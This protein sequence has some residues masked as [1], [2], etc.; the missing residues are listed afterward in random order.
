MP[1][2]AALAVG[3]GL[4][5]LYN[6]IKSGQ[7]AKDYQAKMER[8]ARSS[9][10]RQA[11]PELA[12]YYGEALNRYR[13][14]PFTT[15]YYTESIKQANRAAAN[16]IGAMQSRGAAIGSIGRINQGLMD[17]SN[18]GVMGA[19]QNK[20]T[21]FSQLGSATQMKKA[22]EDQMFDINQMTPYNRMLQLQQLK[23]QAANDRYNAGLSMVAQG[24]GNLGQLSIANA[25][26]ANQLA[27]TKQMYP[28][29]GGNSAATPPATGNWFSGLFGPG[30]RSLAKAGSASNLANLANV[31]QAKM[32]V[33]NS[34][35]RQW[36]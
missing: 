29:S 25:N 4:Y 32:P 18:R 7:E 28:G 6:A 34:V 21:Q 26:N 27:I 30:K 9:P 8:M 23:T 14:N 36:E 10:V 19:I 16:A 3:Q 11:N 2:G 31:G 1:I 17:A 22:E 12:N 13:E 15:P 5:G 33:Y 35:T 24:V 20:N